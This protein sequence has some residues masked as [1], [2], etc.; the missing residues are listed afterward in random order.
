[1]DSAELERRR[2]EMMETARYG[3]GKVTETGASA[4]C[5]FPREKDRERESR[6]KRHRVNVICCL[7]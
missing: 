2:K 1:M 4:N 3:R 5:F 6:V 7:F